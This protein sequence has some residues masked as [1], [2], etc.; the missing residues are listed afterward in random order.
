M[1]R[2]QP[3]HVDAV[4]LEEHLIDLLEDRP[5]WHATIELLGKLRT[6]AALDHPE[7]VGRMHRARIPLAAVMA[8][9]HLA[10]WSASHH[11]EADALGC[12][13]A[14]LV[15]GDFTLRLNHDLVDHPG[16]QVYEDGIMTDLPDWPFD[17][18]WTKAGVVIAVAVAIP[19][20][21][22]FKALDIVRSIRSR[23]D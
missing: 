1:T 9:A 2:N 11:L 17:T 14:R 3:T 19:A 22:I 18:G 16:I 13:Y 21:V 6:H 23:K 8:D 7:P 12:L 10:G 5:E 15:N 20:A 4:K